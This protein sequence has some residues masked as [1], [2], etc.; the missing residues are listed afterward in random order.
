[1]WRK[2]KEGGKVREDK[3]ILPAAVAFS[4]NYSSILQVE[5]EIEKERLIVGFLLCSDARVIL[6]P[7][8]QGF[9][10]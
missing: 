6:H 10:L 3:G 2:R 9:S 8:A 7:V 1:M 5:R 4:A